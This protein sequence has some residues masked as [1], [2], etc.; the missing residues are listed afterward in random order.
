[1]PHAAGLAQRMH[2]ARFVAGAALLACACIA[3]AQ[4]VTF[5][6][7][8]TSAVEPRM[9][10]VLV[11][12]RKAGST[13]THTVVTDASGKF[14]FAPAAPAAGRYTISIRATGFEL[15]SAAELDIP[16]SNVEVRLRKTRDL[17]AQLTNAEWFLSMPGNAEQKRPLIECMSCHTFERIV[18]SKHD[19]NAM[20]EVLKRMA[21]YAINSTPDVRQKRAKPRPFNEQQF[22][23]LAAYLASVNLSKGD[24]WSYALKTL[25]RPLGRATRVLVTEYDLPRKTIAPHDVVLDTDGIAWYSNF[26][27]KDRKSTRLNSSH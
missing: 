14:D 18:R 17:A 3:Q 23:A 22:R 13:I 11:S 7:R 9:E 16:A 19:A 2:R 5:T 12:A 27:D 15:D 24:K 10:G 6:G 1:M 4:S 8:V 21:T 25:P 26:L 20:Y